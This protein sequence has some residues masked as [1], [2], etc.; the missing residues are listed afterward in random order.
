[1]EDNPYEAPKIPSDARKP[2]PW[3][4][5]TTW[6]LVALIAIIWLAFFAPGWGPQIQ[7]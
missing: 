6:V 5:W 7:D 2:T 3:G 4:G 1:M